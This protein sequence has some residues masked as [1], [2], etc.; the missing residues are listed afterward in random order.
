MKVLIALKITQWPL[1]VFGDIKFRAPLGLDK[2]E[3]LPPLQQLSYDYILTC[4]VS[5]SIIF[6]LITSW[7]KFLTNAAPLITL[8]CFPYSYMLLFLSRFNM[9]FSVIS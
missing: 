4:P 3:L 5:Q 7:L 8:F 2:E 6:M 9:K 1:P